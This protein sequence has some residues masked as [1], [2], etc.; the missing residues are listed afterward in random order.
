MLPPCRSVLLALS[1]VVLFSVPASA[2]E[3]VSLTNDFDLEAK[4]DAY[5]RPLLTGDL[6]SGSVLVARGGEILVAKGYGLANREHGIANTPETCFRLGS[7]SKQFTAAAILLLAQRGELA[8]DDSLA[9][10]LPDYPHAEAITLQ[11]LM[12]HTAGVANYNNLPEY[13]ENLMLPWTIDEVIEWFQDAEPGFA[14]GESWGYSNSGYVLLAKVIEIVS[15]QSYA[16]FLRSNIFEP[17][18]MFASGQDTHTDIIPLRATGHGNAGEGIYQAP[19]RDMPFT[20]GAGSLYSSVLDLHLWDR[21]LYTDDLLTEQ[22]RDTMFTPIANGYGCG[23]FVRQEFG[24]PLIEHGGAINGFL[25]QIKRFPEQ[26]LVII[27]LFNY[28][29]TFWRRVNRGLTAM[30][31]GEKYEP[32]L[33]VKPARLSEDVLQKYVGKYELMPGYVITLRVEDGKLAVEA[34]DEPTTLA[35]AQSE[36]LFFLRRD[37]ALLRIH[38]GEDGTAAGVVVRQGANGF[39]GRPVE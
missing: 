21:A 8:V 37:N 17:L 30:V 11:H 27:T 18:E 15:G 36:T 35:E 16:E 14:P 33:L 39:R 23:W 34:P 28:E 19:Y 7:M 31:L 38:L 1:A 22:W 12:T 4:I 24:R 2:S 10:Y 32:A 26:Q 3:P 6:I 20:S 9:K 13:G 25:S 5:L 29:S